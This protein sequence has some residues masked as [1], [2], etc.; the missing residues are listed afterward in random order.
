M[1][2]CK[3]AHCWQCNC[4][5]NVISH[6]M[7][8]IWCVCKGYRVIAEPKRAM[9]YQCKQQM[10]KNTGGLH[11]GKK[12]ITQ[13]RLPIR[14]LFQISQYCLKKTN[15][16][17]MLESFFVQHH[18]GVVVKWKTFLLNI[19]RERTSK[20]ERWRL[21]W[22]PRRRE[23]APLPSKS[24]WNVENLHIELQNKYLHFLFFFV[25][26]S[27]SFHSKTKN[28]FCFLLSALKHFLELL[29]RNIHSIPCRS[30][31]A[32]R[33]KMKFDQVSVYLLLCSDGFVINI[34]S[35]DIPG[36]WLPINALYSR[37]LW[38]RKQ[39]A[40]GFSLFFLDFIGLYSRSHPIH[41]ETGMMCRHM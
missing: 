5:F 6:N 18:T 27:S 16:W 13:V 25:C 22:N 1:V 28:R 26:V 14:S 20:A 40:C 10:C 12:K 9:K 32:P 8:E 24:R 34:F 39:W 30:I 37:K 35:V 36:A 29:Y 41:S 15:R 31:Y 11:K 7:N 21:V 23:T 2:L 38:R 4:C 3:L 17:H 19:L 33:T